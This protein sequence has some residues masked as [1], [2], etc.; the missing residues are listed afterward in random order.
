MIKPL[1][2]EHFYWLTKENSYL[3]KLNAISLCLLCRFIERHMKT[4][5]KTFWI[6]ML[7][8][9]TCSINWKKLLTFPLK[10]V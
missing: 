3:V 1:I 4:T 7:L 9:L 2:N 6:S 8:I 10:S 5:V